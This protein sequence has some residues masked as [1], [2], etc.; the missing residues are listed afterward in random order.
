MGDTKSVPSLFWKVLSAYEDA[1]NSGDNSKIAS[2][3]EGVIA[4]WLDGNSAESKA[5]LWRSDP[6]AYGWE[7]NNCWGISFQVGNI[8]RESGRSAD[9]IRMV[10]VSLAMLDLYK[11]L[12]SSGIVSGSLADMDFARMELESRLQAN[13]VSMTAYAEL[14]DGQG[15]TKSYSAKYVPSSGVYFGEPA[16]DLIT[17]GAKK[18]SAALIYVEFDR[19]DLETRVKHELKTLESIGITPSKLSVIELAWNFDNHSATINGVPNQTAKITAA[20]KYLKSTGL[21]ILLRVGAEMNAFT[22][23]PD[24]EKFKTAFRT[25]AKIMHSDAPN[26]MLLWSPNYVNSAGFTFDMFYPG[27]EHVDWV[28]MSL[29]TTK[30]FGAVGTTADESQQAIYKVGKYANPI[31]YMRELVNQYGARKPIIISEGGVSLRWNPTGENLS[32]WA[33]TQIRATYAYLPILFPEVKA[34]LWFNADRDYDKFSYHFGDS[35]EAKN[36]YMQLTGGDYFIGLGESKSK[37]TYKKLGSATFPAGEIV[38]CT[39]V[40]SSDIPA[41]TVQYFVD[42]TWK[43]ESATVPFRASLDFGSLPDGDHKLLIKTLLR[44]S[45]TVEQE[46]YMRKSGNT[47]EVSS[48]AITGTPPA[49]TPTPPPTVGSVS[50]V[51]TAA[52]VLVGTAEV[53]FE[54]YY[55]DGNNY[56]KLRDVAFA[57]SDKFE[58]LWDAG[59]SAI[60]LVP[61]TVYTPNNSELLPGD[62]L[63][64]NALL[65]AD[66]VYM[67]GA[68]LSLSAYKIGGNNYFKLRDI[69]IALNFNVSW[70]SVNGAIR[71]D[72]DQPYTAD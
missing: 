13:T 62:G 48:N 57:L 44:G 38:I 72:K 21:P 31:S 36:L 70:D 8:Y 49:V 28:G 10:K 1:V 71:I 52:K 15:T 50:A 16:N 40:E 63:E 5:D 56:F 42:G 6:A 59:K 37:V 18:P 41:V 14:R 54:A 67:D 45:V 27:D 33:L 12:I 69:G 29:Y 23:N 47:V 26:V 39:Y 25:I 30:Y 58:V 35:Y 11:A 7:I 43:Q 61:N 17:G 60:T 46:F 19:D 24:P 64:K 32:E 55:I 51:P 2:A 20:A 53:A 65:S 3:G 4:Y 68:E 66:K 22:D 34:V 9:E